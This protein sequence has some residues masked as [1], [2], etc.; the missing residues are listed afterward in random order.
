MLWIRRDPEILGACFS[1]QSEPER[2]GVGV[3][4][5]RNRRA[6]ISRARREHSLIASMRKIEPEKG[7]FTLIYGARR[8]AF[9]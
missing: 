1:C 9:S 2:G 4:W 8:Y 6:A 5:V 7:C 3:V